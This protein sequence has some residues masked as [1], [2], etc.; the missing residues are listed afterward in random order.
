VGAGGDEV[1]DIVEGM[2]AATG[3][4]GS[5]VEGSG[6]AGEL[7]LAVEGPVL[8]QRVDEA[9][10]EDVAG[11]GSIANGN[12][13]GGSV[14]ELLTVEGE[15]AF[16]S[17]SCGGE[18]AGVSALHLAKSLL[19][20]GLGG[21]ARGKVAADDEVV[22]I[23][24]EVFDV[25]V[26]FVEIGYDG[27]VGFTSPGG[28]EDGGFGVEAV[29]VESAGIG[30]PLALEVGWAEG[31]CFVAAGKDGALAGGVDQDEGLLADAAGCGDKVPLDTGAGEGFA[32]ERG[33]GVVADLSDVAGGHAPLL[34]GDD[35][36]G[37]LAAG[38][39]AGGTV[40]HLGAEDGI[41]GERNN[42]V[43]SVES[44]ADKV[45]LRHFGH[46]SN[47]NEL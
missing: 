25:G 34:A 11:A 13:E 27:D 5:A 2:D 29:D 23:G 18:P 15:D 6:G 44:Y 47:V 21:E 35:G 46:S 40:L 31:Q 17:E 3:A 4:D 32:M 43:C 20:I 42:G 41:V 30:D 45:N 7:E 38:E 19:E 39:N 16:L 33:C 8:E 26:E 1:G 36:G 28:G 22:D 24:D 9:G 12:A 37:D 10:V 14:E